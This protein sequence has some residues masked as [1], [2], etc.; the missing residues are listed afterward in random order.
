MSGWLIGFVV[1]ALVVVVVVALL[2][3]M[4]ANARRVA[5]KAEAILDALQQ[6]RD[7]TYGLWAVTGTNLA[8]DRIVRAA[9]QAR[10]ALA[11]NGGSA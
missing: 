5:A 2:L 8:A 6:A 9:T 4:I 1:G 10:E 7:N 11:A 3:L